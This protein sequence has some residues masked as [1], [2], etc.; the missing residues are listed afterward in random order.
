MKKEI[1]VVKKVEEGESPNGI[2]IPNTPSSEEV[3]DAVMEVSN[4][5][6]IWPFDW[7]LNSYTSDEVKTYW[8][9]N[10][11]KFGSN[12]ILE[13][14]EKGHPDIISEGRDF[15]RVWYVAVYFSG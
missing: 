10:L 6:K 4:K 14:V 1:Q 7:T 15:T 11:S 9:R 13:Q 5:N 12:F 8:R 3:L 2:P